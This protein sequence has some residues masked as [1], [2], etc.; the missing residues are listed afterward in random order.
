[1]QSTHTGSKSQISAA[2]IPALLDHYAGKIKI[3]SLDC[4][5]T[6]LWRNTAAPKDVFFAMQETPLCQKLGITAYQRIMAAARAYRHQFIAH[7]NHVIKL[8]DVYQHFPHLSEEER[9]QLIETELAAEVNALYAFPPMVQLI[10]AA[11]ARGLKIVIASDTYFDEPQLRRLLQHCLPADVMDMIDTVFCS[12][13]F[14][15]AKMHGLF[16]I[17]MTKLSEPAHAF[18]H[19]GDHQQADYVA[20]QQLGLHALHFVHHDMKFN[21]IF[22]MQNNAAALACMTNPHEGLTRP[23]R[24]NP[25]R[26]VFA[27]SS[28]LPEKPETLIGYMTFGPMLYAF[29]RFI[30]DEITAL[31]Q[32]GKKPKVFFLLRDAYLLARACEAYAGKEVGKLVHLRKFVCVASSLRSKADVMHYLASL[33]L[34]YYNFWGICEQL[35]LPREII[36]NLVHQASTAP[37]PEKKFNELI[38]SDDI[39]AIV[40][41][42]SAAHRARLMKYI[43]RE[44][45]LAAGDTVVLVDTGYAGVTQSHL[46]MMLRGE[47]EVDVIGRYFIASHEPDR[48]DSKALITSTACD[49]SLFEQSCTFQEGSVLDYDENGQ[50]IFDNIKLSQEQYQKSRQIQ[51]ECIRFIL[52]AKKF[53][54]DANIQPDFTSLRSTAMAAF[55]RHVYLPTVPEINYYQCFQHD[56][57]MGAD[58][59]KTVYDVNDG[60][61]FLRNNVSHTYLSPYVARAASLET[62][63]SAMLTRFFDL[64]IQDEDVSLQREL[65]NVSL[66]NDMQSLQIIL[67]ALSTANGYFLLTIPVMPNTYFGIQFGKTYQWLQVESVSMVNLSSRASEN[68]SPH[69]VLDQIALKNQNLFECLS[70]ASNMIVKPLPLTNPQQMQTHVLQILFRPIIRK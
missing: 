21:E 49:H 16:S 5:D 34:P 19:I 32:A 11:H 36:Q 38:L 23:A 51:D 15:R 58:G 66:A 65:I 20:P 37:E 40:F 67:S 59:K 46:S 8:R 54:Q 27:S 24:Y 47:L 22:R 69:I 62:S 44:L 26:G 41:K 13:E 1:M 10:R 31:Q 2:D 48:P 18:L 60:F 64:E 50:P 4:F 52:N 61:N 3:L 30:C 33:G 43:H 68:M 7:G 12:C 35:L 17:I 42:N 39:L 6:L 9:E 28:M 70:E 29:A 53:F 56:K 25:Y 45:G 57:D 63:L 55:R 14:D